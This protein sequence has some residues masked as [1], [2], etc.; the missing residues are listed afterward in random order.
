MRFSVLG[1]GKGGWGGGGEGWM[2]VG[3]VGEEQKYG[4]G[5]VGGEGIYVL[6]LYYS[7]DTSDIGAFFV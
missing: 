4:G 5:G 1:Y 6:Y 7:H 2:L 3:E